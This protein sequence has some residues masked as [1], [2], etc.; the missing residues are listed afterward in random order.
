MSDLKDQLKQ[1]LEVG[2]G[3]LA[4]EL[5]GVLD[6]V[7]YVA[8]GYGLF[9]IFLGFIKLN[10]KNESHGQQHVATTS[11]II[12][13]FAI[14]A[15]L[16]VFPDTVITL[17]QT[18]GFDHSSLEP[19]GNERK[20]GFLKEQSSVAMIDSALKIIKFIGFVW[21]I[22]VFF[23][24]YQKNSG[25]GSQKT[26]GNLIMHLLGGTFLIHM[27]QTIKMIATTL[28]MQGHLSLIGIS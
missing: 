25:Q 17:T 7:F 18:V 10:K 6:L 14:G 22:R 11:N 23:E 26:N 15:F 16:V 4:N 19:S 8:Y 2:I 21:V 13:T 5:G 20:M 24:L 12:V 9:F 28:G 3:A 27:D 1:S